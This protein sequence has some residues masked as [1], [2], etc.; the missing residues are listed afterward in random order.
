M[1]VDDWRD[2][3]TALG[4]DLHVRMNGGL[5]VAETPDEVTLLET[6]TAR[7]QAY[8]LSTRMIDGDAA[9][10]MV[11]ALSRAVLSACHC[12]DE[13]HADPRAVTPALARAAV[14]AGATVRTHVRVDGIA[15][16]NGGFDV[17]LATRTGSHGLRCEKL[18][19]AAGAFSPHLAALVNIHLPLFPVGLLMNVTERTAPCLPQ[20]IQHAGRRL[21]MK[22]THSGNLLI[23]G[24]WSSRMALS[25][26]GFDAGQRPLL[27]SDAVIANLRVAA[28]VMP[29][30]A[31]LNLIRS[32]TAV[33]TISADQLPI[34]GEIPQQRGLFVAAGGSA[35]TL[36]LTLARLV[37][38][39]MLGQTDDRLGVVAPGRF[40]HLNS[41][42][43][44]P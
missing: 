1:A 22:Q 30:V 44:Q 13:G 23:G 24:G 33:T 41:F 6:K 7:E 36:G 16:R 15:A 42:M 40:A 21:S 38:D 12:P 35:F 37:A 8:G 11:P 28:D 5:M 27:Q 18:L 25:P 17:T 3:E 10:A 20:L 39:A 32:W 31:D 43:G 4:M 34:A 9:R 29:A 19:I 2:L 26:G 14:A